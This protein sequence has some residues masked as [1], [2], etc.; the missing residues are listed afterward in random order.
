MAPHVETERKVYFLGLE[1]KNVA[2]ELKFID[3]QAF[4]REVYCDFF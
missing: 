4:S 1:K 3:F 2:F